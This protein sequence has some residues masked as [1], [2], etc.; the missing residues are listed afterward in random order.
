LSPIV[1][2]GL[3]APG[4]GVVADAA[5]WSFLAAFVEF[6]APHA[7]SPAA[8]NETA[9]NETARARWERRTASCCWTREG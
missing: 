7:D 9:I 6:A 2:E 5:E 3:S 4:N 1:T 8:I